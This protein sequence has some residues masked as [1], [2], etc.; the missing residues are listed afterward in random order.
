V[1]L[2][3]FCK[4]THIDEE[5]G[6][7][8]GFALTKKLQKRR[9]E[10]EQHFFPSSEFFSACRYAC[11]LSTPQAA[12][13]YWLRGPACCEIQRMNTTKLTA[14]LTQCI[15]L[16]AQTHGKAEEAKRDSMRWT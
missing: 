1:A 12:C 14:R 8:Q 9:M 5:G 7:P 2:G 4:Y 11:S 6:C 15:C 16:H 10:Q 13:P 3:C